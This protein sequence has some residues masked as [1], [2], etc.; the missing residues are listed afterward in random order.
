[1]KKNFL[2]YGKYKLSASKLFY[3]LLKLIFNF[4]FL[5]KVLT[6]INLLTEI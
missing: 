2:M 3:Y 5:N 4:Q 6:E 1:M